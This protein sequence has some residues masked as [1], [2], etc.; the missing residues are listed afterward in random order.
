MA[1]SLRPMSFHCASTACVGLAAALGA[2]CFF[3]ASCATAGS[4]ANPAPSTRLAT[5]F[6]F[7]ISFLLRFTRNPDVLSFRR[8]TLPGVSPQP[9]FTWCAVPGPPR[10]FILRSKTAPVMQIPKPRMVN[11]YFRLRGAITVNWGFRLLRIA[12]A[13]SILTLLFLSQRFWYRALWRVTSH[14]GRVPLRV[15]ARL[16]Y[17]VLLLLVIVAMA[18]ILFFGHGVFSRQSSMVTVLTGLW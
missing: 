12:I 11:S 18:Q 10:G 8:T 15:G 1:I 3:A 16:A 5:T 13:L 14:W 6:H 4:T 9:A 7:F 2:S 17:I